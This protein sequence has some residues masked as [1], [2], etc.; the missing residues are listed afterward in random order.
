MTLRRGFLT[1]AI[2]LSGLL[3]VIAAI[4]WA[5][6]SA[7]NHATEQEQHRQKS[8]T[9]MSEVRHEVDLLG[10]LVNSY[11][12][13]ANPRFLHY[14]YDILGI[15]EGSKFR[16]D[17]LPPAFWDEIIAG[18]KPYQLPAG[19]Q[20]LTLMMQT[21]GLKFDAQEQAIVS[22]ILALTEQMKRIE[23]IAFAAT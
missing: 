9:L 8:L 18:S 23:Q 22:R 16:P 12:S 2:S 6:L 4:T 5:A 11:V 21:Q 7:F 19:S 10:R 15:R 1:M 13:T 17:K 3:L 14:Y 20:A